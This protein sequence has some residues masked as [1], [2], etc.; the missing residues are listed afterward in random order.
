MSNIKTINKYEDLKD[1]EKYESDTTIKTTY[2]EGGE[3]SNNINNLSATI[4]HK[5][6]VKINI[7]IQMGN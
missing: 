7:F 5:K 6:T 2:S 1:Q 4:K 3:V